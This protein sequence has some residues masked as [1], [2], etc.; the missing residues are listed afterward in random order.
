MAVAPRVSRCFST[1]TFKYFAVNK[2][3]DVLSQFTS[4]VSG[5]RN[6][7]ELGIKEKDVYPVGRLDKDSEGLLLLSNDP[8]FVQR[9]LVEE[10][11]RKTYWV[12]VEGIITDN[13]LVRLCEGVQ[14]AAGGA[15]GKIVTKPAVARVTTPPRLDNTLPLSSSG[16]TDAE[17][18]W[19]WL[20]DHVRRRKN[21]ATQF[22]ELELSEG[23]NRQVRKMVAGC[24]LSCL[25]LV[26]VKIG[27]FD[28]RHHP[29]LRT[30]GGVLQ[31]K[32]HEV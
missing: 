32:S 29:V 3:Y 22:L 28:L 24:G 11:L 17:S 27:K 16:H 8:A 6:L 1:A 13:A 21:K 5:Q 2:P 30:P 12:Q 9:V 20:E 18:S 7:A 19:L 10:Q 31:I 23:K 4:E 15:G 25:R 26:R 14:I